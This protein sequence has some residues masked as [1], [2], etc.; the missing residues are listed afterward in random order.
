MLAVLPFAGVFGAL[1]VEQGL[2]LGET[3]FASMTIFA[4]ASQYAMIELMGQDAPAWSIVLT[5]FAINF[6]HVLYSASVG[7][8]LSAFS[9]GQKAL[10]FFLLVDPQFAAA[11]TRAMTKGLRPSYYFA[12]ASVLYSTWIGANLAGALFGQLIEN[13]SF[14]GLDFILPLYFTGLVVGFHK[15]PNFLLVLVI[16]VLTSLTAYFT[17]G[18]PWHISVGGFTGLVV[19]AVLSRP[20]GS[21]AHE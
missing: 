4:G 14:F 21:P 8:Y 3:M 19:A 1:A 15:R 11:E 18:S 6:R 20:A 5:V 7:R 9:G 13:P 12:Y 2:S 17:L 10:A 16:S